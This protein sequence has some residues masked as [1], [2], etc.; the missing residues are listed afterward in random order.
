MI[1]PPKNWM[2]SNIDEEAPVS[3]KEDLPLGI[4]GMGSMGSFVIPGDS[5]E[6]GSGS[7]A[8]GR[9]GGKALA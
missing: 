2:R 5:L 4:I 9:G 3:M 8:G 6:K 7:E 1:L